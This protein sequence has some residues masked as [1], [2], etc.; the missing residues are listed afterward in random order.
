[1]TDSSPR[2]DGKLDS[3]SDDAR[4]DARD[5]AH[6]L[7]RRDFIRTTALLGACFADPRALRAALANARLQGKP[8]LTQKS[9]NTFLT[10]A[11]KL[12]A[13]TKKQMAT[14]AK[15]NMAAFL[16]KHFAL[17]DTQKQVVNGY[18]AKDKEVLRNAID[19]AIKDDAPIA[20]TVSS[21]PEPK[22]VPR[23][24][25][26]RGRQAAIETKVGGNAGYKRQF[27]EDKLASEQRS[28]P[29]TRVAVG[30]GVASMVKTY[31]HGGIKSTGGENTYTGEVGIEATC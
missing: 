18:T 24:I 8:L 12:N 4:D 23:P 22:K 25:V 2:P 19:T 11:H 20:V 21:V 1:M 3:D 13:A 30:D 7:D 27:L 10:D 9:L 17:T 16:A 15:A 29:G 14:E 6:K 26:P 5:D 31:A 28:S